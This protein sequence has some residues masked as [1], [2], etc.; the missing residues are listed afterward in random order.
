MAVASG[1]LAG[2][3]ICLT[4]PIG[5]PGQLQRRLEGLGAKVLQAP[6]LEIQPLGEDHPAL[7]AGLGY[8]ARL[9]DYRHIIFISGNA[10]RHGMALIK[11]VWTRPPQGLDWYAIGAGTASQLGQF[12]AD[13]QHPPGPRMDTEALLALPAL[14]S[15]AGDKV[16]IV[17]GLGG[18]ETLAQSLRARGAEVDYLEAYRRAKSGTLKPEV[19]H[20]VAAGAIDYIVVASGETLNALVAQLAGG[21]QCVDA[22]IVVPGQRV[23]SLA[24]ELGFGH[25]VVAANASDDAV[26]EA[27]IRATQQ[28]G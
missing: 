6:L 15:V 1:V 17:R 26:L 21:A 16:L 4:R 28:Q 18:R 22:A 12:V 9:A 7:Q 3:C 11:R 25:T 5:T 10:V 14:Q 13:V 2:K 8:I 27:V 24:G 23:A 20:A 19:R